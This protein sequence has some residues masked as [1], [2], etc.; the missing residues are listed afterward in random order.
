MYNENRREPNTDHCRTLLVTGSHSGYVP[1]RTNLFFFFWQF[2]IHATIDAIVFIN[3]GFS[4]KLFCETVLMPC[5]NP[6]K[7][8]L[9]YL[10]HLLGTLA[11]YSG[12]QEA[13]FFFVITHRFVLMH[14][15]GSSLIIFIYPICE[16]YWVVIGWT[17]FRYH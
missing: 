5:W 7:L 1:F 12:Y 2:S 3:F 17:Y 6:N 10:Q 4:I 11:N 8:H 15:D 16:A 14:V 13:A 9:H